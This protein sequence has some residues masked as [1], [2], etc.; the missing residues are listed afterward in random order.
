MVEGHTLETRT[1]PEKLWCMYFVCGF[2]C[3]DGWILWTVEPDWK[4]IYII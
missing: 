3:I 4:A 2:M 1:Q